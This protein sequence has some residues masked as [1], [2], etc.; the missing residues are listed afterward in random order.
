MRTRAV[1][2]PAP[3]PGQRSTGACAISDVKHDEKQEPQRSD[4]L[5]KAVARW[6]R[7]WNTS[8]Q[9][10]VAVSLLLFVGLVIRK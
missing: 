6:S 4:A 10:F 5:E 1:P 8:E 2:P 7:R 9:V 3:V